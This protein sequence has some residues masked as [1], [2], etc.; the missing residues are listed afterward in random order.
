M[1][2]VQPCTLN[3]LLARGTRGL[4]GCKVC[5]G[6]RLHAT[7]SIFHR[8]FAC[9]VGGLLFSHSIVL[10]FA[11]VADLRILQ[12]PLLVAQPWKVLPK[13][14]DKKTLAMGLGSSP[15]Q[16]FK[17]FTLLGLPLVK[18]LKTKGSKPLC[19]QGNSRD[20]PATR[21]LWRQ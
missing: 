11:G 9:C 5:S 13:Q 8:C 17:K 4:K 21:H 12:D 20:A 3:V 15:R 7:C 2:S 10:N 19:T 6:K 18:T 16:R 1:S 14:L